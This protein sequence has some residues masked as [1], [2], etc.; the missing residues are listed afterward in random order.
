[1]ERRVLGSTGLNV[2]VLAFG[3]AEIGYENAG[4]ASVER[5]LGGALDAGL[6][7]IDTAECYVD[8]EE[9]IGAAVSHRRSEYYLF[10]K[11]GHAS[12][13]DAPDWTP[14]LI[15]ASID[16]S[17]Q[18][19][20][21][22][23]VDLV[24]LHSCSADVLERGDVIRV[25]E[26]A[27]ATGKTRFI[28]YSGDTRDALTAIRTGAFDTLQTSINIA[29][30]EAIELT[31][32]EAVERGMGILAKRSLANAVWKYQDRPASPYHQEYWERLRH[33]DYP[34]LRDRPLGES[35]ATAVRFTLSVP[36][37]AAAIVG[38]KSEERFRQNLAFVPPSRL[39]SEEYER[40]RSTWNERAQPSWEGQV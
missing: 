39:P 3:G 6:N 22:D 32:P 8:S 2:S 23:Y 33:V 1:M 38:S 10:T 9:K 25:L 16:R 26:E 17:L 21:T 20:R 18:R 11:C 29:D 4:V 30:Q 36:G 5:L 28:G 7:V 24:Q 31:V 40:I 27:R 34:F 13:I 14:Q 19:L 12:G 35:L 37:V 15:A